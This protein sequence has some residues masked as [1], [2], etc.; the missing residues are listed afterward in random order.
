[1]SNWSPE[2]YSKAWYF[3]TIRHE[4]QTYGG[5]Q[6]LLRVDYLNHIG[7]VGMEILWALSQTPGCKG[8]LAVQC[9]LL[10]D[11]IEDT[12]ATYEEV[13]EEFGKQVAD[14]VLALTKNEKLPAKEARMTDSLKRIRQQPKEVWM[15]KMADR[16]S[17]LYAPPYYW[18]N[19][20]KKITGK[21]Q[22]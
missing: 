13:K 22:K 18:N 15:V 6:P 8:D 16:I 19:T 2:I 7:S 4:G 14:G 21:K 11:V 12:S 5:S 3:A 9:A 17:N 10:H 20:K 1:M